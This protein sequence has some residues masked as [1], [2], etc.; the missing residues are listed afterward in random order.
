M[1]ELDT[2][3]FGGM[4]LVTNNGPVFT[5]LDTIYD[6]QF[7]TTEGNAQYNQ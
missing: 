1:H 6:P 5:G 3:S 2:S 4:A 7:Y